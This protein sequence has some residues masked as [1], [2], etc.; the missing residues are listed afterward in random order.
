MSGY[1]EGNLHIGRFEAIDTSEGVSYAVLKSYFSHNLEASSTTGT[2]YAF[3]L[4]KIVFGSVKA[5]SAYSPISLPCPLCFF[6][7]KAACMFI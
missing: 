6:P 3:M 7:P 5:L 1:I 2:F 4:I